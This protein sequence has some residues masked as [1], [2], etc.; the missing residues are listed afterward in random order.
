MTNIKNI[1][2]YLSNP[3]RLILRLGDNGFLRLLED[4]RFIQLFC[5]A[6]MGKFVNL[7]NP[8]TFTE[9]LQWLKMNDRRYIYTDMVDKYKAKKYVASIIG[10]EYIIPTLGV[11]DSFE[12][13]DFDSLPEKFVIKCTHDSGGLVICRDKANFDY[14]A[15]EKKITA[16]LK[17]NYYW[18]GREWPYKGVKR[19]II[20]EAFMQDGDRKELRDYKFYC[21]NGEPKFL[22]LSEGLENHASAHVSF[23]DLDWTFTP[24][25]RI[26][27]LPFPELPEKPK[28]LDEMIDLSRRLSQGFPFLRVDLYEINGAVKFGELTFT[29]CGGA[30]PFTPPEADMEI[31]KMLELPIEQ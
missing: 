3:Y 6:Y 9:K 4:E 28:H 27:Y 31:G 30:M 12:E 17:R 10:E 29:P 11:W 23:L 5:K 22:Y 19:K 7:E 21:F 8:Q 20:A 13:I 2:M 24:F 15:A 26:D 1:K 14:K 16:L 25:G 18:V